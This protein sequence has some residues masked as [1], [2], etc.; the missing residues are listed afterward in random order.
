MLVETALNKFGRA[1]G[2]R[3]LGGNEKL[4]G[5]KH[6]QPPHDEATLLERHFPVRSSAAACGCRHGDRR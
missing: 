1:V 4:P 3:D 2:V 6:E 5:H